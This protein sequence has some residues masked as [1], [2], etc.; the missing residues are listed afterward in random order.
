MGGLEINLVEEEQS[1]QRLRIS[2]KEFTE[3][4]STNRMPWPK[5]TDSDVDDRSKA[6]WM[7]KVIAFAQVLWF[8][9]QA[10]GRAIAGLLTTTLELFTLGIIYC[11]DI[12]Y[13]C[14]WNKPFD[15]RTTFVVPATEAV[16]Q[17]TNITTKNDWKTKHTLQRVSLTNSVDFQRKL[18]SSGFMSGCLL[19]GALHIVA[20]RFHFPTEAERWLWRVNSIGCTVLHLIFYLI[21]YHWN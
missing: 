21:S 10:I 5:T 18:G 2:P 4:C 11:A 7:V 15:V 12:M 13:I 17:L 16:I 20:W 6:D 14:W 3:L 19:F 9:V 8:V 1:A